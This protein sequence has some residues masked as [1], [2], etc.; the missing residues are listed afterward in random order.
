MRRFNTLLLAV[1]AILAAG[2]A[3]P[4]DPV[5]LTAPD[6]PGDLGRMLRASSL[7]VAAQEQGRV[8]AQD[9]YAAARQDYARLLGVLYAAGHYSGTI[10][11]RL[12]GREAA[13][14]PPLLAPATIRKVEMRITAGPAFTFGTARIGPLPPGA[15]PPEGFSP[16]AVARSGT[17]RA[18]AEAAILAWREAG[19]AKAAIGRQGLTADHAR[20]RLDADIGVAP[21]PLTRFGAIRFEGHARMREE[22]LVAIAGFPA[23]AIY[24]PDQ[25]RRVADRLRR[26]G[27]FRSATLAEA[28]ALGPGDTL[29]VTAALIEEAPRRLGFGAEVA[30]LEGVTLSGF[31]MHRNLWG[32]A[33]RLRIEG[34][35][36]QIGAQSSGI[37]YKFG[38]T[39]D[40]PATLHPDMTMALAL[41][42]ARVDDKDQDY[43]SLEIGGEFRRIFSDTLTGR[44]GLYYRALEVRDS[45]GPTPFHNIV[46][47][48]GLT[49][50]RRDNAFDAT[51][52]TFL[53]VEAAPYLGFGNTN[54]GARLT[55]DARAF[56][57]LGDRVVLA[58]RVQAGAVFA[59]ALSTTPR[60]YLFYSGG[61]GTVR[62]Q[63]YQSLGVDVLGGQRTGGMRFL[64]ASAEVR[65]RITGSIGAVAFFDAGSVGGHEFFDA[66]G[67]F[68]AGAGVGLRYATPIGPIRL[69]VA[70]PAGGSTG[71]G[72]Q[73]YIGIGQAF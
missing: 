23:G 46:L 68:H 12:D 30:S 9:I 29:D 35:V 66:A 6:A 3:A 45:L 36:A 42:L 56:Q 7:T 73:L 40:R 27:V 33:E 16:G 54:T 8:D 15:V 71:R 19:H 57:P 63:P 20:A 5:E 22:R 67:G 24:S 21:G 13:D 44:A 4:L 38:V 39:Y 70:A 50:D 14:I 60:S 10:S 26:T 11:I 28:E 72:V 49:W 25:M 37:D 48:V 47:P 53:D 1:A 52:G 31:W 65:A 59:P 55:L 32:G 58:A 43:D 61:G 62:G 17:V 64:G 41:R 2:P 18:A 51:R 34:E 69:D